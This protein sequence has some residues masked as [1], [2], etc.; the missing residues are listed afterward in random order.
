MTNNCHHHVAEALNV[1]KYKGK[2]NWSQV[3][4]AFLA[5]RGTHV[6][7][8]SYWVYIVFLLLVAL[9]WFI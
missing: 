4:I 3:D 5:L 7:A 1:L 6:S 8:F 2:I 9:V